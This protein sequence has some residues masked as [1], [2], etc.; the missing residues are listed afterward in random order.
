[1]SAALY[2]TLTLLPDLPGAAC[3]DH[4]PA[5]WD[6]RREQDPRPRRKQESDVRHAK[7]VCNVCPARLTCLEYALREGISTGIWGG[8][9]EDERK[10]MRSGRSNIHR[11]RRCATGQHLLP[12]RSNHCRSCQR[13]RKAERLRGGTP[14]LGP[15]CPTCKLG[16]IRCTHRVV[17]L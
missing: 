2:E 7:T 15:P 14:V 17:T 3:R 4:D 9:T 5:L 12:H 10:E 16:K 13:A 11:R 1:M 6:G 8:K